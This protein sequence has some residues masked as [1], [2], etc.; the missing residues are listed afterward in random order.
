MI[1]VSDED[2]INISHRTVLRRLDLPMYP[3][4]FIAAAHLTRER[5]RVFV[6]MPFNEPHSATLWKVLQGICSIRGLNIH[7]ADES[8]TP[9]LIICDILEELERAEIII[10][11]IT[12]LNPNVLYELG[13]AHVRCDSV[14]IL[15]QNGKS[16]PF[17]LSAFRCIFF[18]L[19][20]NRGGVDLSEQ[21]GKTLDSLRLVG[22]PLVINS[23]LERTKAIID[24]LQKL[25]NLPDDE[26]SRETV[27]FSGSLSSFSIPENEQF[28][29]GEEEYQAALLEEKNALIS[30]ARRG[31]TVKCII[32]PFIPSPA[33]PKMD[34]K[35]KLRHQCL[36]K[37]LQGSDSALSAIDWVISPFR[38]KNLY[39][40]GYI[41]CVEGYKKGIQ[42]G[43]DLNLRQTGFNAISADI[44]MYTVLFSHLE[45]KTLSIYGNPE[46]SDRREA[47]KQAVINCLTKAL[48]DD[49]AGP[50][51]GSGS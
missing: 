10:A 44:S 50:G 43:F 3:K 9:N 16:V 26:I 36:L 4:A 2:G 27:W 20:D 23:K 46:I 1:K 28:P 32:T 51:N 38:Q 45:V 12:G 40:I 34:T 5:D 14:I 25:A 6:A 47:L 8:V 42:R 11:D 17:D 30:L 48:E 41:S 13:I 37:F 19:N 24:D 18:D 39:I 33:N 31:C 15:C 29:P 21:L 49:T 35:F 7:R 22:P